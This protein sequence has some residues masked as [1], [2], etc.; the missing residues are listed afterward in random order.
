VSAELGIVVI[1]RNEGE[2]LGRA[3]RSVAAAGVATVYV[4]SDSVDG[5]AALAQETGIETIRLDAAAEP[6]CA[7]R[8]R[9][10]GYRHMRTANPGLLFVQFLDADCELVEGWV[11]EARETLVR[12]S[13]V[14]VVAGALRERSPEGSIYNRVG[15][16]EWNS[17]GTGEVDSVGGIFMVRCEAFDAVGGFDASVPAGEEPE[18][19][20]R[21]RARGWKVVRIARDMAWH[22]LAITRFSEWWRRMVRTGYGGID[23]ASRFGIAKFVSITRRARLWGAWLVLTLAAAVAGLAGSTVGAV[24]A[25]LLF[26]L[27]PARV[28]RVALRARRSGNDLRTSIVHAVL[29]TIAFLPQMVGQVMY[30]VDRLAHRA[31][32][33]VEYK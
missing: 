24:F 13:D 17:A 7:A 29:T 8:S 27:A 12:R 20:Q 32:R 10:T 19:C 31:V 18:F 4:D 1:G 28:L 9:N 14:A 11:G 5:S 16:I 30:L 3:L 15:E 33:L 23:V 21:L 26:A 22:D 25:V 6:L 2:R